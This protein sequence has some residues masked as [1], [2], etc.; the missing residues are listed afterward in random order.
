MFVKQISIFLE[1]KPGTLRELT[2]LLGKNGVDLMAL[3]IADTQNFGIIRI[4]IKSA[5]I[6][7]ALQLLRDNGYTARVNN[8]I[9]A[10]VQDRPLGLCELLTIIENEGLAVEY[11]YSFM[12]ATGSSARMILRLSY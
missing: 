6:D 1:N 11:M 4:I 7:A 2:E 12:R 3:S 8:V 10:D 5:S 9:C